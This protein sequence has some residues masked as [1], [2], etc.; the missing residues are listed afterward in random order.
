V[1]LAVFLTADPRGSSQALAKG[2]RK[3]ADAILATVAADAATPATV[4]RHD[5]VSR[6]VTKCQRR[7]LTVGHPRA[8]VN[9]E[10]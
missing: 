9:H 1:L 8:G 7:L 10:R 5:N 3:V 4:E 6:N 2:P